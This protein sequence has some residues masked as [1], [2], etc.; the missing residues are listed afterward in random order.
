MSINREDT[1]GQRN[2]HALSI[3]SNWLSVKGKIM[4]HN[5]QENPA[6]TVGLKLT[7]VEIDSVNA[8]DDV[9][10]DIIARIVR[11][12]GPG[13]L[14]GDLA[15]ENSVKTPDTASPKLDATHP[16]WKLRLRS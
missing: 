9:E 3:A 11:R 13:S 5:S 1:S 2:V 12:T 6:N 16:R 4:A 14:Q 7:L 15:T 10:R 8:S